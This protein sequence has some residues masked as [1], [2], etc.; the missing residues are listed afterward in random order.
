MLVHNNFYISSLFPLNLVVTVVIILLKKIIQKYFLADAKLEYSLGCFGIF[1][2]KF[3]LHIKYILIK[4]IRSLH[5]I[6]TCSYSW[7]TSLYASLSPYK[8]CLET[9]LI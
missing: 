3:S 2:V 7:Y 5:L 4:I 1:L 9:W 6:Y 8:L